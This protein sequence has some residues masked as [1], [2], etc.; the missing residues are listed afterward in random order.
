MSR[1][2]LRAALSLFVCT[3]TVHTS[4]AQDARPAARRAPHHS[5]RAAAAPRAPARVHLATIRANNSQ[6]VAD[7]PAQIDDPVEDGLPGGYPYLN[8]PMYP[9]PRPNI[10]YQVGGTML[11]NQAFFPQEML[12][13][14]EYH[15]LY[16]PYYHKVSGRWIVTP[17][18]VMSSEEWRL[19]G[20]EVEVEYKPY[21]SWFSGF[22]PPVVR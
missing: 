17:W 10:P 4:M 8:A 7:A 21:I 3:W 13:P 6:P 15:A 22:S 5:A 14:H 1:T 11:T 19:Q 2:I 20:T 16:P 12:H 9:T 18:G